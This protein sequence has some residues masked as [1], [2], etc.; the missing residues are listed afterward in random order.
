MMK[1][2]IQN[3]TFASYNEHNND[4]VDGIIT[5]DEKRF[6]PFIKPPNAPIVIASDT[7]EEE[8][9]ENLNLL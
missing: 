2:S 4:V 5:N 6:I 3:V 8:E 9:K 1:S 7:E